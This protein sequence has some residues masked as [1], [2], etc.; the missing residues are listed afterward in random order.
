VRYNLETLRLCGSARV[1]LFLLSRIKSA[2]YH[3]TRSCDEPGFGAGEEAD[4]R[5]DIVGFAEMAEGLEA[6]VG[7]AVD[8]ISLRVDGAGLDII[9]GDPIR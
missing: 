7:E 8:E 3:Q 4:E 1:L 5:G 9:Y 6:G 2:I